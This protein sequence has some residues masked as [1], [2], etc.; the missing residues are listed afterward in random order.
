MTNID[1]G[2]SPDEVLNYIKN[3]GHVIE[4]YVLVRELKVFLDVGHEDYHPK[5]K[6]RIWLGSQSSDS[7]FC[8]ELSH[9]VKT[10]SQFAPYYPSR[11]NYASEE[12]AIHQAITALKDFL[13]SAIEN[14][15]EPSDD[16][17]VPDKDF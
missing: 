6:I 4:S 14:G 1:N 17:L 8:F 13:I 16:W 15:E 9:N 10:P 2:N 5:V 7:P 11:T 12:Q 3:N